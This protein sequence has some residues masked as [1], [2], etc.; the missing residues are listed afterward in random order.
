MIFFLLY[1]NENQSTFIAQQGF[2][3]ILMITIRGVYRNMRQTVLNA[4]LSWFQ[5]L[6]SKNPNYQVSS[7]PFI[8]YYEKTLCNLV[9]KISFTL[10]AHTKFFRPNCFDSYYFF[11]L[12]DCITYLHTSMYHI[13]VLSVIFMFPDI[14][15]F[16]YLYDSDYLD[17]FKR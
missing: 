15:Q 16:V 12:Y 6:Y 17:N 13:I 5:N 4:K 7:E 11:W 10:W 9:K 8:T 3:K 1:P 14:I 2:F